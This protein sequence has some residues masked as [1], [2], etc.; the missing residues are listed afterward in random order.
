MARAEIRAGVARLARRL[1]SHWRTKLWLGAALAALFCAGFFAVERHP[2]RPVT[3]LSPTWLDRAVPFSPHWVWVYQSI[4]LLL[5]LGWLCE[6]ADQ[7]RRYARGFLLLAAVGFACFLCWPIA[8][9]RPPQ[10]PADP[11]YRLLVSYDSSAN[12]FPSLH[13]ALAAYAAATAVAVTTGPS[14]RLFSIVL[15]AW[16][17]LI[18]YSTLA[19]KQHYWI[20]L[21]PGILLG[22][23][24]QRLAFTHAAGA[25]P[26]AQPPP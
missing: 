22:W 13:M 15:P 1:R 3:T 2:L 24:A 20:D 7:I 19:T 18:A 6:T 14:R 4:Y 10:L 21:P 8:G 17:A 16:V 26:A 11:M 5:P 23:L 12:C 25:V 9:P